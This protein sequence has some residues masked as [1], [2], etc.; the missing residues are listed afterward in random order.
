MAEIQTPDLRVMSLTVTF[1]EEVDALS[2]ATSKLASARLTFPV[3]EANGMCS[4]RFDSCRRSDR[5]RRISGPNLWVRL[6]RP[7]IASCFVAP[8]GIDAPLHAAAPGIGK[9]RK[10]V[11]SAYAGGFRQR[12]CR[13]RIAGSGARTRDLLPLQSAAARR[14]TRDIAVVSR[15]D[16]T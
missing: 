13:R 8:I 15:P 2:L 16:V 14:H 1:P 3:I 11:L 9:L 4:R 6:S 5:A 10:I 12:A 7:L